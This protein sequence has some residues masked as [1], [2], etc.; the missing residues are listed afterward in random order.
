MLPRGRPR[1][2]PS[3][4][5][6]PPADGPDR[7]GR[8][9]RRR[10]SQSLALARERGE[11]WHRDR[12]PQQG[13][14]AAHQA[15]GLAKRLF[16]DHTQGQAKFDRKI[17]VASLSTRGCSAQCRPQAKRIFA[18]PNRQ[19]TALPQAFILLRPVCH[20]MLL[21][22]DLVTT[23]SV[24]LVR[25]LQHPQAKRLPEY[26][27]R[28]AVRQSVQQ[29]NGNAFTKQGGKAARAALTF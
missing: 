7:I 19:I 21:R 10:Q 20:L 23:I 3:G 12:N 25:H 26:Q 6:Y 17:R 14:D 13:G 27:R 29:R 16:E 2:R 18:D 28:G 8:F 24:E 1:R 4:R 11:I 22:R 5:N 15:L 9:T